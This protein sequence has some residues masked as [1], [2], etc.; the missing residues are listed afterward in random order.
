MCVLISFVLIA[1]AFF[2]LWQ[3]YRQTHMQR[4]RCHPIHS[5]P[6]AGMCHKAL[7]SSINALQVEWQS[8]TPTVAGASFLSLVGSSLFS[9]PM[10]NGSTVGSMPCMSL[11]LSF[12][13][14]NRLLFSEPTITVANLQPQKHGTSSHFGASVLFSETKN[15]SNLALNV[16]LMTSVWCKKRWVNCKRRN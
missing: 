16:W 11:W 13:K 6:T 4:H 5:S 2:L 15:N 10:V 3:S 14:I 8:N 12:S 1:Q 9:D 7:N